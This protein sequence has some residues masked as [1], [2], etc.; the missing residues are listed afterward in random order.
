MRYSFKPL[1]K[2][3]CLPILIVAPFLVFA[4]ANY[5]PGYIINP[6]GDTVKGFVNYKDWDFNPDVVEFKKD[7]KGSR[8]AFT[9]HNIQAFGI[10]TLAAYQKA[11]CNISLDETS[12]SRLS[13]GRDTSFRVDTVFL[14]V[15]QR[16]PR[17]TLYSYT[18]EIKTRFYLGKAPS[19]VPEELVYRIYVGQNNAGDTKTMTEDTYK[20]VL[21][22]IAAQYNVLDS[23]LTRDLQDAAYTRDAL[24][25]IVSV[26]NGVSEAD[27][28]RHNGEQ[29]KASWYVKLAANIATTSSAAT[30]G[31]TAGGGVSSTSVLPAAGIG[32]NFN[33]SPIG[34]RLEFRADLSIDPTREN[35]LYTLKVSPYGPARTSYNQTSILFCPQ[36]IVDVY[37]SQNFNFHL[38]IGIGVSYSIFSGQYFESQNNSNNGFFPQEPFYFNHI[39]NAFLIKAGFTISNRWEVYFD[40]LTATSTTGGDYFYLSN[41]VTEIGLS[42]F[43]N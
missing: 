16:G 40:Y 34:G 29:G 22:A 37:K 2:I 20:K 12:A 18:D 38:G 7:L 32:L 17:V 13:S 23:K 42:Y 8:Q 39:N 25:P 41:Q 36:M 15:L 35:A 19:Y 24:M 10:T 6:K 21:F 26:I 4:Q 43:F 31:F 9:V 33:P 30:S 5:R 3:I 11:A 28:E 1:S 27:F 14:K